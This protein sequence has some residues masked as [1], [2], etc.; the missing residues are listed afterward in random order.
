MKSKYVVCPKFTYNDFA[1][2]L[3]GQNVKHGIEYLKL[4]DA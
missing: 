2:S 3:A 4:W 1:D